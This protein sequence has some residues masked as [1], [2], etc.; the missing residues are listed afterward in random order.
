MKNVT[1][2]LTQIKGEGNVDKTLTGK[3]AFSS[4]AFS[5]FVNALANDKGFKV[6]SFDKSTGKEKET[7]ISELM[8]ADAKKTIENAKFPQKSE[9]GVL[10]TTEIATNGLAQAIPSIVTEWLRTGKKFP[11]VDQKDF[12]GSINLMPVVAKIKTMDVRDMKTQEK[13]GTV[14]VT[15]KDSVQVRAKSP[16]PAHLQTKVRKDL[17]GNVITK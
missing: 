14:T 9:I 13:V 11:L 3:G 7:N 6:K 1:D 2:V 4:P 8:V 16:V 5:S 10:N 15:T 17:N 12:G